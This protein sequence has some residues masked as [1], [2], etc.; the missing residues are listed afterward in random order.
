MICLKTK[1]EVKN[2]LDNKKSLITISEDATQAEIVQGLDFVHSTLSEEKTSDQK[3]QLEDKSRVIAKRVTER[4]PNTFNRGKSDAEIKQDELKY[5]IY[6]ESGTFLHNTLEQIG[7]SLYA[8]TYKTDRASILKEATTSKE[9]GLKEDQFKVLEDGFLEIFNEVKGIQ[10]SIDPNGKAV[11]RF[12]HR[13]LDPYS[14]EA[15]T[16][17]LLVIFSD[18]S[19]FLFDFKSVADKGNNGLFSK[20]KQ[21]AHEIQLSTY[22]KILLQHQGVKRIRGGRVIPIVRNFKS[23]KDPSTK[24]WVQTRDFESV[25]MGKSM[26]K[27]LQ[28][29]MILPETTGVKSLD[30]LIQQMHER[31]DKVPNEELSELLNSLVVSQDLKPMVDYMAH[32]AKTT[33]DHY[34]KHGNLDGKYDLIKEVEIA[35]GFLDMLTGELNKLE[36]YPELKEAALDYSQRITELRSAYTELSELRTQVLVEHAYKAA[37]KKAPEDPTALILKEESFWT[38]WLGRVTDFNN[39]FFKY[40]RKVLDD[41]QF[42]VRA[43]LRKDVGDIN[44]VHD[45]V[46]K[47]MKDNGKTWDDFVDLIFNRETENFYAEYSQSFYEERNAA[48]KRGDYKWIL[49]RYQPKAEYQKKFNDKL[50]EKQREVEGKYP[51][52]KVQFEIMDQWKSTRD[53]S[54]DAFGNPAFPRAWTNWSNLELK[55]SFKDDARSEEFKRIRDIEPVYE[56]YKTFIEMNQRFRKMLNL[57]YR[58]LPD[59]FVPFIRKD[60][61][62]KMQTVGLGGAWD[63][64]KQTFAIRQDETAFGHINDLTGKYDKTVPIYFTN[65]FKDATG[66]IQKGEKSTDFTRSL[67]LFSKM[68]NNYKYM[69]KYEANML[70]MRDV[71]ETAK[72]A[73][74]DTR[75]R[76]IFNAFGDLKSKVDVDPIKI[77]DSFVDYYFYGKTLQEEGKTVKVF[78]QEVNTVQLARKAKQYFSL[79]SL[80]LAFLPATASYVSAGTQAWMEGKEGI[81]Y[82]AEQWKNATLRIGTDFTRYNSLFKFF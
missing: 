39:P 38:K 24:Q 4:V 68:A 33:L 49:Q 34:H 66:N 76:L 60:I 30:R 28:Q 29:R 72:Y 53:L 62:E 13:V 63:E 1:E 82:S 48:V 59:N 46:Q 65:P 47:W 35:A 58:E 18:G 81:V 16:I 77:F 10:D 37:N 21:Q 8:N 70:A 23:K 74:K 50:A 67:I 69:S 32:V 6:N 36:R 41:I 7:K 52:K 19:G 73:K 54:L 22:K 40:L 57:D 43:S 79:K 14:D 51:D 17:D 61:I 64:L 12:E 5:A 20:A 3:Y 44:T 9:F 15:G 78:G 55:E 71:L 11:F 26:G 42:E 45:N 31:L 2:S 56:Y 25:L 80:G 75:G 27:K